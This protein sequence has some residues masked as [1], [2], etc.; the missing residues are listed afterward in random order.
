MVSLLLLSLLRIW[1][2]GWCFVWI[3]INACR[4]IFFTKMAEERDFLCNK[5][6]SARVKR[7]ESAPFKK[8]FITCH[9]LLKG[10]GYGGQ[11]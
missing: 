2:L 9:A 3:Y 7:P 5:Y 4:R 6:D 8:L 1:D 11:D 10:N